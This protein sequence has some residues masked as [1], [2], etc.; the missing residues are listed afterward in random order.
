MNTIGKTRPLQLWCV[1]Q[2]NKQ[3]SHASN[4]DKNLSGWME[5]TGGRLAATSF[6]APN[7]RAILLARYATLLPDNTRIL[8]WKPAASPTAIPT[9]KGR[10]VV[11]R[12]HNYAGGWTIRKSPSFCNPFC[13]P[14]LAATRK[15]LVQ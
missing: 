3:P 1:S 14:Q 11:K 5:R 7:I 4:C 2:P 6:F 13:Q 10:E 9:R 12:L 8:A 15:H